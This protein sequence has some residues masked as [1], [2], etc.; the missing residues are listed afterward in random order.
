MAAI[1]LECVQTCLRREENAYNLPQVCSLGWSCKCSV[2]KAQRSLGGGVCPVLCL[3]YSF[4][5][6]INILKG[7]KKS[8]RQ[9][10]QLC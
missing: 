3:G 5:R 10:F 7:S 2:N 9:V 8:C 6:H 4:T 1:R